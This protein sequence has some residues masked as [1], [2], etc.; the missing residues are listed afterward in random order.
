MFFDAAND[1][2]LASTSMA[3]TTCTFCLFDASPAAIGRASSAETTMGRQEAGTGAEGGN[4][5]E[6]AVTVTAT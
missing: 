5:G 4:R 3:I 1:R 2:M 6:V